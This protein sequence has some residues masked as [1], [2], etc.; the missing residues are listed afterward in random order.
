MSEEDRKAIQD[1]Y[2]ARDT[3][4]TLAKGKWA[5]DE[6]FGYTRAD[7]LLQT[8]KALGLTSS[9]SYGAGGGWEFGISAPVDWTQRTSQT[10]QASSSTRETMYFGDVS[11]RAS[12]T[13]TQESGQMPGIVATIT[14]SFPTGPSPYR[15]GVTFTPGRTRLIR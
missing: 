2:A 14:G 10:G 1:L 3:T 12:K 15:G 13:I 11:I 8:S 5:W 6:E 4:V 7:G 9:L